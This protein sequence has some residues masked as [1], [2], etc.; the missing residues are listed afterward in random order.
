LDCT[1]STSAEDELKS[2]STARFRENLH[3]VLSDS[4]VVVG[5]VA[6]ELA[7]GDGTVDQVGDLRVEGDA[8]SRVSWERF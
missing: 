7:R 1:D 8:L 5:T 2:S 3:G 4:V 6:R